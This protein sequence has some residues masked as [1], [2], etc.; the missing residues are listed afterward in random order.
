MICK[1]RPG[2]SIVYSQKWQV[3]ETA[4]RNWQDRFKPLSVE[5]QTWSVVFH[6]TT[7]HLLVTAFFRERIFFSSNGEILQSKHDAQL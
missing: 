2:P 3:R 6:Y 5:C 7:L 1:I 4:A